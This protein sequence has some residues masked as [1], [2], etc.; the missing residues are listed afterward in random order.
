MPL[1]DFKCQE[2][3][4]FERHVKLADFEL[5]QKC[6]CG[7]VSQRLISAPLFSVDKTDYTCPITDKWIGSK[8]AHEDNLR[9]HNSRVLEPG[10]NEL[11][12]QSC[13]RAEAEFDKTIED[14]VEKTLSSWDSSKMES[15][16]NEL[17]NSNA[18][19]TLS[20]S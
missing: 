12:L 10:E 18:D 17:I 9:Q 1:Y 2:G 3:H 8:R 7:A 13:K 15:L 16:S 5:Q 4:K 19:L 14:S 6:A 11:N 20:R